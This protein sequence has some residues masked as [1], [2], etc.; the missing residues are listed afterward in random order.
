MMEI[1]T[2]HFG[3][4]KLMELL[5]SFQKQEIMEMKLFAVTVYGNGFYASYE[6]CCSIAKRSRSCF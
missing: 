5:V 6:M 1:L 4:R 3:E 2:V